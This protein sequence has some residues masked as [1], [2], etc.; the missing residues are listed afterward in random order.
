M[1]HF[2]H[3]SMCWWTPRHAMSWWLWTGPQWTWGCRC[4]PHI[5]TSLGIFPVVGFLGHMVIYF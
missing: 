1:P 3:P 4:L 5:V 2:L